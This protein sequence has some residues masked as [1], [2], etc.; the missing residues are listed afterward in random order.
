MT[1]PIKWISGI[2][3]SGMLAAMLLISPL[4]QAQQQQVPANPATA[5]PAKPGEQT[6]DQQDNK[7]K[8][9]DNA[10]ASQTQDKSSPKNDRL[11][12]TLPNYL[13]VEN[14]S[15]VPPLSTGGKYKLVAKSSFDYVE[16]PYIA[17]LAAISQAQD[18]EP[19]FGQG[20]AGYGKRFG[21]AFADNTI[22]NFMTGAVFPSI[23]KQDPR[24]FQLGAGHGSVLHRVGYAI[25][26]IF[27]TRT[28]SGGSQ[29]NYSEIAGNAVAAGISNIYHPESDRTVPNT[30]SIWWT[31]IM[32]DTVANE[33]KE[34]W[35]DLRHWISKKRQQ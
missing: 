4:A 35:P 14:A 2:A 25:G 31:E 10:P 16:Y 1:L 12:Y 32:W 6:K 33:A 20:A 9:G 27:V 3:F 15:E 13:T 21:A 24:Y 22:G 19:G 17:A 11:F 26:R 7:D 29:F 28:D 23:L 34:F 18:S 8:K 5:P 30:V